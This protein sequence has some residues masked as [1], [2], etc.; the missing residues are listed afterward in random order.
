[1]RDLDRF[2]GRG[3]LRSIHRWSD[4]LHRQ[5]A[6]EV[7]DVVRN[8][9]FGLQN[10]D[11]ITASATA[12]CESVVPVP[13][14]RARADAFFQS[15]VAPLNARRKLQHRAVASAFFVFLDLE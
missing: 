13:E 5:S 15:D 7:P 14:R 12:F 3:A 4:V 9:Q 1:M 11:S 8:V 6:A 10:D 2:D